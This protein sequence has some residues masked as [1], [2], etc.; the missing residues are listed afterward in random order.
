MSLYV[1]CTHLFDKGIYNSNFNSTVTVYTYDAR[2]KL[3]HFMSYDVESPDTP[4][5]NDGT[6]LKATDG[7]ASF[8]LGSVK[9]KDGTTVKTMLT[10]YEGR[11]LA[12]SDSISLVSDYL[13]GLLHYFDEN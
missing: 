6:A 4:Y 3:I 2:G 10:V 5:P 7:S 11:Y 8:T 9:N 1:S 13:V 12:L